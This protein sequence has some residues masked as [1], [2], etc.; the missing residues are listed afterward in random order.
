[1]YELCTCVSVLARCSV[2][3]ECKD[4]DTT[5]RREG[6]GRDNYLGKLGNGGNKFLISNGGRSLGWGSG[7]IATRVKEGS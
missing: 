2:K 7:S 6:L 1:M 5:S 4:E 3:E